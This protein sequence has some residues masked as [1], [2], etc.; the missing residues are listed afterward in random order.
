LTI[1][2]AVE[3]GRLPCGANGREVGRWDKARARNIPVVGGPASLEGELVETDEIVLV[4]RCVVVIVD[5][6]VELDVVVTVFATVMLVV[7]L[8]ALLLVLIE[9]P[10]IPVLK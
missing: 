7:L 10:G 6:A 9:L 1:D 2:C 4:C 3:N 5:V 8:M